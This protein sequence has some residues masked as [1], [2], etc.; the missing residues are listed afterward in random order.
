MKICYFMA[1]TDLDGGAQ[2]MLDLIRCSLKNE[3]KP[4]VIMTKKYPPLCKILNDLGVEYKIIFRGTDCVDKNPFKT[5]AKIIINSIAVL[6]TKIYLKKNNIDLLH[7]NSVISLTGMKAAYKLKIPYICHVR[8]LIEDG[9]EMKMISY[10]KL[11]FYM[12]NSDK[13]IFISNYVKK[14]YKDYVN[15]DNSEVIFDGIDENRYLDRD[16]KFGKNIRS[17]L[18]VGRYYSQ[19]GQMEAL[20]AVKIL[21]DQYK[22]RNI[23]L[24]FIGSLL[25][26]NYYNSLVDYVEANNLQKN[27]KFLFFSNDLRMLRHNNDIAIVSSTNEA[28]GRVTVEAMLANQLVIGANAGGT[29]EIIDDKINGYTYK[30]KEPN[31]LANVLYKAINN[32][33]ESLRIVKNGNEYALKN[34]S[35]NLQNKKVIDIYNKIM[36]R[37]TYE[38]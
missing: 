23:K 12:N 33:E 6:R 28:M 35:N 25:D 10:K 32:V 34:F 2:S 20:Q 37:R 7:N 22:E 1:T 8:E 38:R 30:T 17:I 31:D 3:I 24:T 27:V 13:I 11:Y 4:Y 9:L 14:R 5:I 29:K 36:K 21:I 18:F 19:K 16:K 15:V 26:K